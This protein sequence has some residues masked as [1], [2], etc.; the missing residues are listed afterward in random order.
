MVHCLVVWRIWL[1]GVNAKVKI[2]RTRANTL[3]N[4]LGI[5]HRIAYAY[6][7]YHPGFIYG[8]VLREFAGILLLGSSNILGKNKTNAISALKHLRY[9]SRWYSG[10][11]SVYQCRR[12]GFNPWVRKNPWSRKWQPT[13]VFLPGK[14]HRHRSLAG[15]SLGGCKESDTAEHSAGCQDIL[16]CI[17][18]VKWKFVY[19]IW[20]SW[21]IVRSCFM[22]E[23]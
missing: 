6:R 16:N 9:L 12:H 23:E 3:P 4:L 19:I 22:K 11:E 15:Y 20:D 7:K 1:C 10:K 8:D 2:E 17:A 13:L 18:E 5:D 14:F 21:G